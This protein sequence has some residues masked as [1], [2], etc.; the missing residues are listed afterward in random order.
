MVL[1]LL[2]PFDLPLS[3]QGEMT[4]EGT[5]TAQAQNVR[6]K[7][8]AIEEV[9]MTIIGGLDIHRAQMTFDYLDTESGEVCA[10]QVR[11]ATRRSWRGWLE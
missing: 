8:G 6:K 1:A 4:C 9:P 10:G 5:P 11:P 2:R 3:P 7:S